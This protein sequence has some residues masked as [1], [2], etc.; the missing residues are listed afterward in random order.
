VQIGYAEIGTL[1]DWIQQGTGIVGDT[2]MGVPVTKR[3]TAREFIGRQESVSTRL[4]LGIRLAEESWIEPLAHFF[5]AL[6]RQ[7]LSLP[8][9]VELAGAES[10]ID[11]RGEIQPPIE[12]GHQDVN[13]DL[14]RVRARGSTQVLSRQG[15]QQ[16]IAAFQQIAALNPAAMI[17]VDWPAFLR[18]AATEFEMPESVLARTEATVQANIL[19]LQVGRQGSAPAPR[20]GALEG[21]P[22]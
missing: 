19:A 17:G 9:Q 8:R 12:I 20:A 21:V 2:V 15:R 1:S 11:L 10:L 3:Q 14:R 5:R 4:H 6:N 18:Y 22:R 16:M 7:F 13:A